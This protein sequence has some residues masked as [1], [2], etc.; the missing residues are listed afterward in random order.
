MYLTQPPAV[1]RA[2]LLLRSAHRHHL[3]TV[4]AE[5]LDPEASS[6]SV[7]VLVITVPCGVSWPTFTLN[8]I[9]RVSWAPIVP[10]HEMLLVAAS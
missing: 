6:E 3:T 8:S 9:T 10:V 1:C 2:F 5:A 7:A 4:V